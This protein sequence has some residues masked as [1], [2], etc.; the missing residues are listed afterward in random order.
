MKRILSGIGLILV[1]VVTYW[2]T[3]GFKVWSGPPSEQA[4]LA[5]IPVSKEP[6]P[7]VTSKF[8]MSENE[9]GYDRPHD[10]LRDFIAKDM[11]E[12][13]SVCLADTYCKAV[14]FND[15]S[16]QCWMKDSVPLRTEQPGFTVSVKHAAADAM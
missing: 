16:N 7:E 2:L 13:K 10:D 3:E 14:S 12:C 8:A 1:G 6:L 4:Q 5:P 9:V 15:S 11:E